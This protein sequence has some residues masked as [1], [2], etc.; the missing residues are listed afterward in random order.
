MVSM[1]T[2]VTA[3]IEYHGIRGD[4]RACRDAVFRIVQYGTA[5]T[6]THILTSGRSHCLLLSI[7]GGDRVAV[8]SG[9]SSGFRGLGPK[10]FSQVLGVL[11]AVGAEIDEYVVDSDV[12]ERIDKTALTTG[13]IGNIESSRAVRPRRW[14]DYVLNEHWTDH[15]ID[16]Q[17]RGFPCVIPFAAIDD[18]IIDLAIS[19][20]EGP[21]DRVMNGFRRLED[22]VRARAE[23]EESGCRLF[24][25]EFSLKRGKLKWE[26]VSD[27]EHAANLDL[28]MAIYRSCRNARAHGETGNKT[29]AD[30][31]TDFIL[32]NHLYRLER[33][34]VDTDETRDSLPNDSG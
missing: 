24:K 34:A 29:R 31:L 26:H 5:I 22:I 32:L 8:K 4:S 11:H 3:Q 15:E 6:H 7:N 19:F 28:M 27:R 1:L 17:W 33:K 23:S 10:A 25:N 13:D 16:A 20:W 30:L 2:S 14:R 21:D 18:R 9:F 12:I